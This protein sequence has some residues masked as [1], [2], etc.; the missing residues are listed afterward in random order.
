MFKIPTEAGAAAAA[1]AVTPPQLSFF[2]RAHKESQDRKRAR[3]EKSNYRSTEHVS[4]TSNICERLFS[5]AKLIMT[6][7]RKHMDPVT[8]NM[9][10]FLKANKQLWAEKNIIDEIIADFGDAIE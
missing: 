3:V 7:L 2:E 4:A 8:L 6:H 10:L 1:A 5:L 9:I